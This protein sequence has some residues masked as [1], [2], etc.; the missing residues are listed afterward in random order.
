MLVSTPVLFE[1]RV[2]FSEVVTPSVVSLDVMVEG[3]S[4]AVA[5][6][7]TWVETRLSAVVRGLVV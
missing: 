3:A 2:T 6:I 5:S 1:D 7:L 4:L